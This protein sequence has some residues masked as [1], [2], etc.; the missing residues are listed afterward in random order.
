MIHTCTVVV[1]LK[2]VQLLAWFSTVSDSG[3]LIV[4]IQDMQKDKPAVLLVGGGEGMGRIEETVEAIAKRSG[5]FCQVVVICGRNRNLAKRLRSHSYPNGMNVVVNGFVNNMNEWMCA[6]DA[7]ITKAGPGTIAEALICGLPILLNG[8]IPGQEAGNIPYV[9]DNRVGAYERNPNKIADII[10]DWLISQPDKLK[11]MGQRAKSLGRPQV[12]F[13]GETVAKF[14]Y[15]RS[16]WLKDS[17]AS[18]FIAALHS[19]LVLF[20]AYSAMLEK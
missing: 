7:I 15:S 6:C 16:L 4:L 1:S 11:E 18:C 3:V 9:V 10:T 19:V 13:R 8:N 14:G 12:R 5:A 20:F 17:Q 2:S